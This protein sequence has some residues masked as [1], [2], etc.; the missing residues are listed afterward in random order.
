MEDILGGIMEFYF[1]KDKLRRSI[2][3][4]NAVFTCELQQASMELLA[5]TS[6]AAGRM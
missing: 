3:C 4:D 5:V 1:I 6:L 2:K